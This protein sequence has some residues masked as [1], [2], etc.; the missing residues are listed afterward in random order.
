ML[1]R[2]LVYGAGAWG[3]VALA[4]GALRARYRIRVRLHGRLADWTR[5]HAADLARD[6]E[7]WPALVRRAAHV[8]RSREES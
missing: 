6:R 2:L 4:L 3:L 7:V 1:A 5:H 8:S